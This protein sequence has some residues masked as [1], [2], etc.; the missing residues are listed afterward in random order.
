MKWLK[1]SNEQ[2][3]GGPRFLLFF[4]SRKSNRRDVCVSLFLLAA[5]ASHTGRAAQ[6][7][8]MGQVMVVETEP[9]SPPA[10]KLFLPLDLSFAGCWLSPL[11]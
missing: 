4:K 10:M 1:P 6:L 5:L 7:T 8:S 11:T 9:A 3:F 2:I